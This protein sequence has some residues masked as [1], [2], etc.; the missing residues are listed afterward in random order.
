[1]SNQRNSRIGG[2]GLG[3]LIV[4]L[5]VIGFL[6]YCSNSGYESESV[7][8]HNNGEQLIEDA[9]NAV[10]DYNDRLDINMDE[11]D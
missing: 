5:A 1:M 11:L 9:T 2:L 10:K 8:M 3:G 6:R 7:D 4:T